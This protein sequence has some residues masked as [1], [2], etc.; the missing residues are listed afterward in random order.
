MWMIVTRKMH[1]CQ[2]KNKNVS[3]RMDEIE[4]HDGMRKRKRKLTHYQ[5]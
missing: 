3:A 4:D 1:L 2:T 5:V